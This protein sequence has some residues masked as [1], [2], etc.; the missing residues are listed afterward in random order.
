MDRS[1]VVAGRIDRVSE[2]TL[3]NEKTKSA[4]F[5]PTLAANVN[6]DDLIMLNSYLSRVSGTDIY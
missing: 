6:L 4:C 2:F 3:S 5:I 1:T